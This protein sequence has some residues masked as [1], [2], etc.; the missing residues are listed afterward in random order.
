MDEEA[1]RFDIQLFADVLTD[2]DQVLAARCARTGVRFVAMFNARQML[3]QGL[4]TGA[5]TRW[6]RIRSWRRFVLLFFRQCGFGG[7][8]VAGQSFLEQ[9]ALLTGEGLA[10]GAKAHPAKMGQFEDECLNLGLCGVKFRVAPGNLLAQPMRLGG[11]TLCLIDEF[12]NG[13]G[14]PIGE[15]R[16]GIQAGQFSV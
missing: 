13:A 2:L 11:F 4:T 7:G 6:F 10:A 16:R 9:V 12:L 14:D 1:G 8:D 15:F 3:G 5:G